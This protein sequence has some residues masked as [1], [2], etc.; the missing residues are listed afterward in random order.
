MN[1]SLGKEKNKLGE[2]SFSQ[3]FWCSVTLILLPGSMN[4]A[5]GI[6]NPALVIQ[7]LGGIDIVH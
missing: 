6:S 5:L 2:E 1:Y 3:H 4:V 7:Q